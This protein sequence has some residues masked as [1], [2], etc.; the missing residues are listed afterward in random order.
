MFFSV[1]GMAVEVEMQRLLTSAH[2]EKWMQDVFHFQWFLLLGLSIIALSMWWKLLN[3]AR[4][5]EVL[6]YAVFTTIIMMGVDE[7][8]E[9]L[10]L[11]VYPIYLFPV[12]PVIT[13]INLTSAILMLSITHQCFTTWKSF[14]T[15]TIMVSGLLAF[16]LEPAFSFIN[17]Y[18]LLNWN[19]GYN[20]LLYVV[21]GLLVR[22]IVATLFSIA[23]NAQRH[24]N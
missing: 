9:E 4:L 14:S 15:A 2:I 1:T 13:A 6:L 11:W 3:K 22:G 16:I 5:P 12:F 7:C 8:G 10:T 21:V 24:S 19:Y 23:H 20:F 17:L 18:Q